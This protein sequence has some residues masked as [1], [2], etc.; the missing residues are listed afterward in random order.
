LATLD[1]EQLGARFGAAQRALEAA[2]GRSAVPLVMNAWFHIGAA[3]VA[4]ELIDNVEDPDRRRAL[5]EL[6]TAQQDLLDFTAFSLGTRSVVTA[7]DLCAAV[8]WR[9]SGGQPLRGGKESDVDHAFGSRSKL[10]P[11]PLLDWL[12]GVHD[13]PEYP[14]ITQFRHGFTHRQVSRHATVLVGEGH[15]VFESEVGS[16]RQTAAAHLRMAVPF[17]VDQFSAFCDAASGQVKG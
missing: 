11:G 6:F 16:S 9:L 3:G 1:W 2:G 13:R 10:A 8:V 14:T 5:A 4:L 7:L 15:A 12:V 17:A